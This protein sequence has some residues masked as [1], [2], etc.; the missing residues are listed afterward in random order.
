MAYLGSGMEEVE[1]TVATVNMVCDTM[2][3]DGSTTTMTIGATQEVPGSVNNVSVYFDGVCQRPTTD[4]TLSYKTVTFTTAPENAVKVTC[5]SY[6]NEFLD[7]ISDA[8][9]Y[10]TGIEDNAV[11]AAKLGS[12]IASSKLTGALPA[13]DGSAVTNFAP[14]AVTKNASDPTVSTN[15]ANG[16]GTVWANTTSGEMYVLTDATAGSNVWTNIG[17]GTGD[18]QPILQSQGATH[19]WISGGHVNGPNTLSNQS[20]PF[21]TES[22]STDVSDLTSARS[23]AS[24][25]SSSTH[26]YT[27]SGGLGNTGGPFSNIIDKFQFGTSNDSTDVG[28]L[29]SNPRHGHAGAEST[30]HG[31]AMGGSISGPT[32]NNL[33]Q[34]DKFSFASDGNASDTTAD[35][36]QAIAYVDGSSSATHGYTHGGQIIPNDRSDRIDKFPFASSASA[37]DVG[38]LTV[39]R[40]TYDSTCNSTT[41]GYTMGGWASPYAGGVIDKFTFA[42]DANATDVGDL[43]PVNHGAVG[44]SGTNHGYSCGGKNQPENTWYNNI[45]R[46]SFSSDGNA[47]DSADLA[48]SVYTGAGNQV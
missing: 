25:A 9:V 10:S 6:A 17:G 42:S 43:S 44:I 27:V 29:L 7:V 20:F 32:G 22:N 13:I 8:T 30:T 45:Q 37:T 34:I 24:G 28:D 2:V 35:L 18:V 23:Y 40:L 31:Y 47:T 41:H 39:G 26:G 12:T 46:F 33:N 5:L 36:T 14:R 16:L 1:K 38:N 48:I 4:Y 19:G 21:A 15:P 3:G 11:T